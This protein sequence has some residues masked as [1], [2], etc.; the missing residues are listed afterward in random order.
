MNGA[1]ANVYDNITL[2]LQNEQFLLQMALV[3][4]KWLPHMDCTIH[5]DAGIATEAAGAERIA[6][7]SVQNN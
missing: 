1:N 5:R 7:A 4:R 2:E 6:G 3:T